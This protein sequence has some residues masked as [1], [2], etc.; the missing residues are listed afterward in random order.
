[1][2]TIRENLQEGLDDP[3][4]FCV[5]YA[6]DGTSR[7]TVEETVPGGELDI[8]LAAGEE[9]NCEW[10]S[11]AT[12]PEVSAAPALGLDLRLF[13]CPAPAEFKGGLDECTL[14]LPGPISF[15]FSYGGQV[16]E[17][18]TVSPPEFTYDLDKDAPLSGEWT[19]RPI[20]PEGWI[21]PHFTCTNGDITT[22]AST[23]DARFF[24]PVDGSLG[25]TVQLNPDQ[26][27]QCQIWLFA[28]DVRESVV[29]VTRDCPEDY[30]AATLSPG[31]RKAT[32]PGLQFQD[33]SV[34]VDDAA[35]VQGESTRNGVAVFPA[36]PGTWRIAVDP[37][38]GVEGRAITFV[39]CDHTIAALGQVQ[40][41]EPTIN[42]DQR[43]VSI[44][45]DEGDALRCDFFFGPMA[46][47]A[48]DA[49]APDVA[50]PVE[51]TDAGDPAEDE[52]AE[53]T[54]EAD[55]AMQPDPAEPGEETVPTSTTPGEGTFGGGSTAPESDSGTGEE[56][57]DDVT[58]PETTEGTTDEPAAG[59]ASS[60]SIQHYTCNSPVAGAT[61]DD[62]VANCTASLE[63]SAWALN[64]EPLDVVD[65]YAVWDGLE[66]GTVSVSNVAAGGNDDTASAV[67][68]SIAP[69]GGEPLVAVEVPV[70]D[71]AIEVGF[72]QPAVVYCAWFLGP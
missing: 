8:L 16:L 65:G 35:P 33:V 48:D 4:A 7:L 53:T 21:D 72:D 32:C 20:L 51:E 14:P 40:T 17:T 41:I 63:P 37:G 60:L 3:F 9:V 38:L 54:D 10:Y 5:I 47:A 23:S 2:Y 27:V 56:P 52:A 46:T 49:P 13:S 36:Q 18:G 68:C 26:R 34:T 19:I 57:A 31:V 70:K 61:V 42:T 69:T 55:P 12:V 39:T 28:G 22:G 58:V 1:M 44:A 45:L 15:E 50:D 71:G 11:V 25:V 43:S 30:D 64:G 62:L 24:P 6:A 66:P 67:Y 29:V 59:S